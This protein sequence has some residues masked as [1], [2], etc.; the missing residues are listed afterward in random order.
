MR[1]RVAQVLAL[2][3]NPGSAKALRQARRKVE[4]RLPPRVGAQVS[5]N[6]TPEGRVPPQP[7]ILLLEVEKR[8]HQCLGDIPATKL[9]EVAEAIRHSW[10][11]I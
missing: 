4:R 11:W 8:R 2:E 3:I 10:H 6:L 1:T 9:T 7:R 5:A